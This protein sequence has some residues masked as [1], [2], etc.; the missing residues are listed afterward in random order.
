M[1]ITFTDITVWDTGEHIDLTVPDPRDV[2]IDASA[3]TVA[4]GFEDPHV[5]FRDPGQ[6][7]KEDIAS[8]SRA[9]AHG[10]FTAVCAMPNTNPVCDN[11]TIV[12]YVQRKASEVGFCRVLVS[13]DGRPSS[14]RGGT[15]RAGDS[16]C[17]LPH[18]D[19]LS[20]AL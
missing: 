8:G 1:A 13:G 5:H 6:E 19:R 16:R 4:P 11:A 12:E 9:A 7:Q 14:T 20:A 3:L 15:R 18:G 17:R 2:T 10:G